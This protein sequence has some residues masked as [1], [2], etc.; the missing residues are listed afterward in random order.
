MRWRYRRTLTPPPILIYEYHILVKS[1][2]IRDAVAEFIYYHGV[3]IKSKSASGHFIKEILY[4]WQ[5]HIKYKSR[6]VR[7]ARWEFIYYHGVHI[8]YK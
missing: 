7:A 5:I 6:V 8:K 2:I 3:F 4:S 1:K